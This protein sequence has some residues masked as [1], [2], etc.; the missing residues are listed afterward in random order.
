[1]VVHVDP[2][3][4]MKYIRD[5]L[6]IICGEVYD[7]FDHY[8]YPVIMTGASDDDDHKYSTSVPPEPSHV[9]G[10]AFDFRVNHVPDDVMILA[11][12]DVSVRMKTLPRKSVVILFLNGNRYE[13]VAVTPDTGKHPDHLHVSLH[14]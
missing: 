2:V 6:T 11:F 10:Y 4:R 1:M 14:G 5:E 3:V 9:D 8:G 7:V 13:G 12:H